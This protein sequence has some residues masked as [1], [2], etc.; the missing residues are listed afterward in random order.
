MEGIGYRAL[1]ASYRGNFEL[2][3]TTLTTASPMLPPIS[4]VIPVF[5]QWSFTEPCLQA[6]ARTIPSAS[7]PATSGPIAHE[8]VIVD[9]GSTD[10]TQSKLTSV[11]GSMWE[12]AKLT[13]I[14][15]DE[16]RGFNEASNVG[17]QRSTGEILVFLNNDTVPQTGWLESLYAA[18]Q[19]PNV[20]IVGPKLLFPDTQ[21][22]NHIGYSF[23]QQLGGYFP[24]YCE[25]PATFPPVC[26]PREFQ[27]LLGACLMMRR[28]DFFDL[29]MFSITGLEDI[30]LCLKVRA[31]GKRVLYTPRAEVWHHGGATFR[32]T[33]ATL[34]P[35]MSN[36][37]FNE[38]WPSSTLERDDERYYREDGYSV[39]IH[40]NRSVELIPEHDK[41]KLIFADAERAWVRGERE[42]AVDLAKASL[43][44]YARNIAVLRKLSLWLVE[45]GNIE[46]AQ[47]F[48]YQIEFL[49]GM[50]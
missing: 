2:M 9:N 24:I 49:A 1:N 28:K 18:L 16:N 7:G 20:G 48:K 38:R 11:A 30:D 25:R 36:D 31:A 21:T 4:L 33:D 42:I 34:I 6:L 19:L 40:S 12:H 29:G 14:R 50:R 27:A 10:L 26:K 35:K 22:I 13:Y 43:A 44:V 37:A 5:N 46:E 3:I 39:I 8:I 41:A 23:N 32:H 17:A 45:M 15:F 47:K